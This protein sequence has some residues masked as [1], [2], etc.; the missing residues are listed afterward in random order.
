MVE[1]AIETVGAGVFVAETGGDLEVAVDAANHEE[2]LEL[3]G[4][5]REGIEFAWMQAGRDEKVASTLWGGVGK[6][7]SGDFGEITL[8]HVITNEAIELRATL[9]EVLHGGATE[10]EEAVFETHFLGGF[11]TIVVGVDRERLGFV[12]EGEVFDDEFDGAGGD[13]G[14]DEVGSTFAHFAGGGENKFV[15][16]RFGKLEGFCGFWSDDKLD[17]A[18]VVAEVDKNQAT[19]ITTGVDPT[20]DGY[21]FA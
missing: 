5:L 9:H 3:L 19:M 18:G 20:S 10:V 12:E 6:N 15:A 11:G 21:F 4:G 2:L 16:D 7:R 8:V 17:D 1:I 13:V 14:V